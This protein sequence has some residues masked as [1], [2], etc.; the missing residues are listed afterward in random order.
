M[1]IMLFCVVPL[2]LSTMM[3]AGGVQGPLTLE[4]GVLPSGKQRYHDPLH[5]CF[6]LP[7][8]PQLWRHLVSPLPA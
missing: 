7:L 2:V 3:V 5:L 6:C 1:S 4:M 8:L